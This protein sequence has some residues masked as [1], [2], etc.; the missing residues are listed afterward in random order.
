MCDDRRCS[1]YV[2]TDENPATS[3]YPH[4]HKLL[5]TIGFID[6]IYYSGKEMSC[7]QTLDT[8]YSNRFKDFYFCFDK[9]C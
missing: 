5:L 6:Y 9:Y 1:R 8:V 2:V 4:L 7:R 3:I